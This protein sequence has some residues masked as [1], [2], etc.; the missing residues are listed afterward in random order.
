MPFLNTLAVLCFASPRSFLE[1]TCNINRF[2]G[3]NL[4]SAIN[5]YC[6]NSQ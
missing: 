6:H 4:S 3:H 5:K 2:T 1:K